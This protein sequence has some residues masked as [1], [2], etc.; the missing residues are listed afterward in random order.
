MTSFTRARKVALLAAL[1][2][3]AVGV[4]T[5]TACASPVDTAT[6]A[7]AVAPVTSTVTETPAPKT[8][9]KTSTVEVPVTPRS[10]TDALDSAEQLVQYASDA[11]KAGAKGIGVTNPITLQ[12]VEDEIDAL[13]PKVSSEMS[14][15]KAAAANC[16]AA[17]S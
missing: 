10:C 7:A 6:A 9:T 4:V 15:Y 8:V 11:L 17:T 12:E 14:T 16:R 2:A 13:S 3:A 1:G 5:L